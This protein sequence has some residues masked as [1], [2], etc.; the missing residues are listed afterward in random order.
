MVNHIEGFPYQRILVLGLAKTGTAVSQVLKKE[1][2]KVLVSDLSAK[3]T[4]ENVKVLKDLGVTVHLGEPSLQLLEDV[5]VIIK[6]PGIPYTNRLLVEA[7][8]KHLP[9]LTEIE[10]L[11]YMIDVPIIAITGSNGKTTTTTLT[12]KMLA[13]SNKN[14]VAAGN[15]GK[16]ATD[17]A[18]ELTQDQTLVLELSSFQ[19]MGVN[20]FRPTVSVL[21]NLFEAH[22]DYHGDFSAYQEAKARIF[23]AQQ[24]TDYL[25]YNADNEAVVHAVKSAQATKIPF[26]SKRLLKNGGYIKNQALYFKDTKIIDIKDIKLVGDHNLENILA[27]SISALLTGATIEGIKAVLTTFTG[28][29]HRLQFVD[30][31]NGVKYYNDSKATNTLATITAL[32]AFRSPIRLIAG[33]LDRGNGFDDLIPHLKNVSGIYLYGETKDKLKET[34]TKVPVPHIVTGE[35]LAEVTLEAAKDAQPG[36]IVLLSPACA[37]WDQFSNFE[38]RGDIFIEAV[39]TL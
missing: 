9:I 36:E 13:K 37:S 10:L 21:L 28:V 29:K 22:L 12:E 14:V 2:F 31:K 39:H 18:Y 3:E 27:S 24:S 8:K 19:L 34:A 23:G 7:E 32:E 30:E 6:N 26:S 38:I 35:S 4:D 15:I 5:D 1:G 33:G 25:V 20:N 16:V 11:A 17:I